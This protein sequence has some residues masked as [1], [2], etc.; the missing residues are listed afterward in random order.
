MPKQVR[1]REN[2]KLKNN[3]CLGDLAKILAMQAGKISKAET[4]KTP[5]VFKEKAINKPKTIVVQNLIFSTLI[6]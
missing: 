6:C 1:A 3:I 5:T 2:S 4:K